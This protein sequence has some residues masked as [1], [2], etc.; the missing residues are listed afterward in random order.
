MEFGEGQQ[1]DV[2]SSP[3]VPE[4]LG[5]SEKTPRILWENDEVAITIPGETRQSPSHGSHIQVES[6]VSP[7]T[8]WRKRGTSPD[9]IKAAMS[10]AY[11]AMAVAR[12]FAD[13]GIF[14]P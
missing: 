11:Y 12:S 13:S 5:G 7:V 8:D 14:P 6:K 10:E 3:T 9:D 1:L 2:P 4:S